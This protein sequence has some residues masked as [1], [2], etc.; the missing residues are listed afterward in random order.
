MAQVDFAIAFVVIFTM[1]AYSIFIVS[2]TITKDFNYF[3]I[4]E[5]EKSQESLSK[6]LFETL[7]SKSLI[8]NFK[9]VQISFEEIGAY[10]HT[11][12]LNISIKPIMGKIH[13]YNQTIHEIA[14]SNSTTGEYVNISF[15][16]DFSANQIN[17]VKIFYFG[18]N[19]DEIIYNNNIT[20]TNVT[21]RILSEEDVPVLSQDKCNS[22]KG[23]DYDAARNNFGFIRRFRIDNHCVYGEEPP[24]AANIVVKSISLFVEKTDE[25]IYPELV[26][27]KVW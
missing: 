17:Y 4:K 26:T 1:I 23:L 15:D 9:V 21:A 12:T 24:V 2:S 25:T 11:E 6:Q 5:I 20:Q 3:N 22:L 13:V 19:T 8:S 27:L 7:D 16:L 18:N 14:S 10:Q